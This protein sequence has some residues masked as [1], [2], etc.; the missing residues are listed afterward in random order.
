MWTRLMP[1]DHR[2][3]VG[4]CPTFF[5]SAMCLSCFRLAYRGPPFRL[6]R[7]FPSLPCSSHPQSPAQR[8]VMALVTSSLW[9]QKP[10]TSSH[11]TENTDFFTFNCLPVYT[12]LS[13][14]DIF[15]SGGAKRGPLNGQIYSP[16]K[17]TVDRKGT[18]LPWAKACIVCLKLF[19]WFHEIRHWLH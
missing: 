11:E 4:V 3:C 6:P 5:Q 15:A 18:R 10:S 19:V 16:E 9:N 8:S 12:N 7:P 1:V 13:Y 14:M 17:T 2:L